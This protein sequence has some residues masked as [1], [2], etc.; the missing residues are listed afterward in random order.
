[1]PELVIPHI[2]K[3]LNPGGYLIV[4][5]PV[6]EQIQRVYDSINQ[7]KSFTIPETEEVMMRRWD[8]GGN[9]TRP[10]TQMLGHTAFLTFS[11]RI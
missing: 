1:S 4:Y 3:S 2:P 9:K 10:K 11:R 5:S 8:I 6:I 7:S